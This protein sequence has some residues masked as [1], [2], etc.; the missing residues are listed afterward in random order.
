MF[1][2]AETEILLI[3]A[4]HNSTPPVTKGVGEGNPNLQ[5]RKISRPVFSTIRLRRF[6]TNHGRFL[7]F[8]ISATVCDNLRP[9]ATAQTNQTEPTG[10]ADRVVEHKGIVRRCLVFSRQGRARSV[11]YAITQTRALVGHM[12]HARSCVK[13]N[14]GTAK[15]FE[16]SASGKAFLRPLVLRG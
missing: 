3:S 2:D 12:F 7:P 1:R 8:S 9:S 11:A 5:S 14:T 15:K 10:S 16:R 13:N 6:A 4:P